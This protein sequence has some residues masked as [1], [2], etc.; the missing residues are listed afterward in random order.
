[1]AGLPSASV[2]ELPGSGHLG[3]QF[4]VPGTRKETLGP[5][6]TG[7]YL[8]VACPLISG[9][10]VGHFNTI[11]IRI[12]EISPGEFKV[13]LRFTGSMSFHVRPSLAVR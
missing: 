12:T 11:A 9:E 6:F 13:M 3:S 7:K 5:A 1:M 2:A 8:V 10:F 4:L